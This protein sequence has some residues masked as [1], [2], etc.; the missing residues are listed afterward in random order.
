[1]KRSENFFKLEEKDN[2][3]VFWNKI[4]I[5]PLRDNR[6]AFGDEEYDTKLPD[7]SIFLNTKLT[8]KHMDN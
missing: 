1:M 5:K 4:L 6:I 8:T 7:S 2:G 3:D